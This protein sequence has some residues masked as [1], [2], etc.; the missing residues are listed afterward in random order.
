MSQ[1]R[2]KLRTRGT[3]NRLADVISQHG[4]SALSELHVVSRAHPWIERR[5]QLSAVTPM[6]LSIVLFLIANAVTAQVP[7][8]P[9]PDLA[10]EAAGENIHNYNVVDSSETGYRFSTVGGN[11]AQYRSGVNYGNGIRLLGSSLIVT[12]KDGHGLLFDQIT[13]STQGLGNDPYESVVLRVEKNR[14][15]RYDMSWRQNDYFNP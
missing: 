2:R 5:F 1:R 3:R 4:R 14:S 9:T 12:S 15:Y 13:L 11:D 7:V 10:G 6:R 8:A